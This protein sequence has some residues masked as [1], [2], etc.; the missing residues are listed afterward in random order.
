MKW[1]FAILGVGLLAACAAPATAPAA[2]APAATAPPAA[3][4]GRPTVS[5][6][7]SPT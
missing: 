4:P 7:R 1:T 2:T 6:F 3:E 5:V